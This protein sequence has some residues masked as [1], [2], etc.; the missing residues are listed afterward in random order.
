VFLNKLSISNGRKDASRFFSLWLC[1]MMGKL[2]K[3]DIR[4]VA[5]IYGRVHCDL[6]SLRTFRHNQKQLFSPMVIMLLAVMF[7]EQF[8][9]GAVIV[10]ILP[11]YM[12]DE[13]GFSAF[14]IGLTFSL[15]YIGDNLFRSPIGW[16]IDKAGYKKVT[17]AGAALV[18]LSLCMMASVSHPFWIVLSCVLLG[19][20]SSPLW[21]C[22]I[23]A[24]TKSMGEKANGTTMSVIYMSW[25]TGVGLGP[26]TV[27]FFISDTFAAA[28]RILIVLSALTVVIA[29]FLPEDQAEKEASEPESASEWKRAGRIGAADAAK[30]FEKLKAYLVEARRSIHI[31]WLFYPALFAHTFALGL[32]TPVLTLYARTVLKLSPAQYS[33]FLIAGGAIT[34]L[35]LL[36]VGKLVDRWGPRWFINAGLILSSAALLIFPFTL[37]LTVILLL[38]TLTGVGYALLIPSWTAFVASVIPKEKR[39]A[40]WGFFLTIEGAGSVL[41]PV[42]SGKLW[43]TFGYRA[44]FLAGGLILTVMFVLQLFI[45]VEKRDVVR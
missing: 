16:L 2:E 23:T 45:F 18:F 26:V 28:F 42:V 41:G 14:L 19:V 13:L 32:L 27:N 3:N 44:P 34:I 39:G 6:F 21:P 4:P 10:S 20:G 7:I 43:D 22:V 33:Y 35:A 24:I 40:I 29:L 30:L 37:S 1:R 15:L 25:M 31:H 8:V 36:P 17:F 9:K 38:V 5:G 12:Q 11:V